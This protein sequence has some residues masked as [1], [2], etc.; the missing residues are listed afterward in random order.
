MAQDNPFINLERDIR[1]SKASCKK[2]QVLLRLEGIP[3]GHHAYTWAYPEGMVLGAFKTPLYKL[4]MYTCDHSGWIFKVIRF[5]PR[6]Y[7]GAKSVAGLADYQKH[8][9]KW[10]PEYKLHSTDSA[11]DGAWIVT[12]NF[13]I[14]DGPDTSS[15]NDLIG[16]AGCLEVFG[17]KGFSVFNSKMLELSGQ[18]HLSK[19]DAII[20]YEAATRP[21]WNYFEKNRVDTFRY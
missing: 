1:N 4:H 6:L 8:K 20:E 2:N 21:S 9:L 10:Y 12:G 16:T 19:V 11:E 18:S 13:L 3:S 14:H 17:P 7:K 5:G 15:P